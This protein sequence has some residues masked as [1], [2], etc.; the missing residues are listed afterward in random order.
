[1][2]GA[3]AYGEDTPLEVKM[4]PRACRGK[5]R[6][7]SLVDKGSPGA[8]VLESLGVLGFQVAKGAVQEAQQNRTE[9][10]AKRYAQCGLA[11][12]CAQKH[13]NQCVF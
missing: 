12:M 2:H 9:T 10:C 3:L 7:A 1:M 5:L 4:K 8:A 6:K 13:M 11:D